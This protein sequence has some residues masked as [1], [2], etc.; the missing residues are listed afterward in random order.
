MKQDNR[1]LMA[2]LSNKAIALLSVILLISPASTSVLCI[3]PGRHVAIEDVNAP[4]CTSPAFSAR[5]GRHPSSM[6][7]GDQDCRNCTDISQAE[8]G[9][10]PESHFCAATG[11]TADECF[12]DR[13][14]A[15]I[16]SRL[17]L[18]SAFI[19]VD[20]SPPG[21]SSVPLRC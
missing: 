21:S 6:S 7:V 16:S 11:S 3:A 1:K 12:G 15:I 19:G 20:V 8:R 17:F 2:R 5:V 9:A 4:C 14:S 13:L 10:I 18:P